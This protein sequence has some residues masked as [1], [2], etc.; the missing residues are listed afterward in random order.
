MA[1]PKCEVPRMRLIA[2]HAGKAVTR[3]VACVLLLALWSAPMVHRAEAG[4]P[5]LMRLVEFA[6]F[7]TPDGELPVLCVN[8]SDGE[9]GTGLAIC[10][11]CIAGAVAALDLRER[12]SIPAVFVEALGFVPQSDEPGHSPAPLTRIWQRGPPV[13]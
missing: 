6:Q 2:K 10:E 9:N 12:T 4:E 11:T 5:N 13:A 7:V 8:G 3:I 1:D